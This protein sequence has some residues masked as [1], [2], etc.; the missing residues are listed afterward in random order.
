MRETIKIDRAIG[1]ERGMNFV[2]FEATLNATKGDL[3]LNIVSP[4][5][6]MIEGLQ[7]FSALH[8]KSSEVDIQP[9]ITGLAASMGHMLSLSGSKLPTVVD[10][11]AIL[12][13]KP[14]FNG[15]TAQSDYETKYL[16]TLMNSALVAMS[17]KSGVSMGVIND[18]MSANEGQGTWMTADELIDMGLAQGPAIVTPTVNK[19][20]KMQ[21]L[22]EAYMSLPN[23]K[24]N[25]KPKPINMDQTEKELKMEV[26]L[27]DVQLKL[28]NAQNAH[29]AA[30]LKATA[31]EA[32][33][34]EMKSS[35]IRGIVMTAKDAGKIKDEA[36]E[37]WVE[38]GLKDKSLLTDTLEGLSTSVKAPKME[39]D[40]K[41]NEEP[42]MGF[43]EMGL[44]DPA[45][46]ESIRLENPT[47]FSDMVKT[48]L[49]EIEQKNKH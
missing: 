10:Y 26:E 12:M 48:H 8:A 45:K 17:Q 40:T 32:E 24:P 5:G 20:A 3:D 1:G 22:K 14:S 33:V 7:M 23:L 19:V 2:D 25:F 29:E 39:L 35:E 21:Q 4:G 9:N 41:K 31:L 28:T 36:V 16:D 44:K 30:E 43:K 42:V 38:L 49:K 34:L 27:K 47:L 11:A 15:A 46:L 18:L 6:S 37:R 13:H